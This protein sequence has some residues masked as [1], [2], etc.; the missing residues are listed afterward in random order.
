VPFME[1]EVSAEGMLR[2]V[3]AISRDPRWS[4]EIRLPPGEAYGHTSPG[5]RHIYINYVT[6]SETPIGATPGPDAAAPFR[7]GGGGGP[8]PRGNT[9]GAP[10]G[11]FH[12]LMPFGIVGW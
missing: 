8:N 12:V 10:A 7:V 3:E 11:A 2:C 9:K 1:E 4:S 6:P 5:G